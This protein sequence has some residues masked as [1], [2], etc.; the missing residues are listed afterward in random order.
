MLNKNK[1]P[2]PS[3]PEPAKKAPATFDPG[4]EPQPDGS[5]RYKVLCDGGINPSGV[6]WDVTVPAGA[7]Q[8][9]Y[10]SAKDAMADKVAEIKALGG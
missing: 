5:V 4:G 10:E 2:V 8:Q 6:F 1:N 9:D 3:K 7:T